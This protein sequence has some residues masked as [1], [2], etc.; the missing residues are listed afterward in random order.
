MMT[1]PNGSDQS[2]ARKEA[3]SSSRW[4]LPHGQQPLPHGQR[5]LPDGRRSE[6]GRG[7]E[8]GRGSESGRR[9]GSDRDRE[10]G[11]WPLAYLITFATYDAWLHGD[12]RGSVDR[13][14]N[15]PG[16]PPLDPDEKRQAR[17]QRRLQHPPVLLDARARAVVHRTIIEVAEHRDWTVHALN[18]RS[19]H[20]HVVIGAPDV[21][22]GVMNALKSWSTRRMVKAGVAPAG[23]KTWVRHGSTRYLWKPE[24][25]EAACQY[26]CERQGADLDRPV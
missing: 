3:A 18:V 23:T 15:V 24:Q 25:V 7:S 10:W 6:N 12:G 8:E 4:A 5:P 21:P 17:E 16:T 13:D 9:S 2:L 1:D 26:V 20:V 22:E 19:N 11:N 14:H